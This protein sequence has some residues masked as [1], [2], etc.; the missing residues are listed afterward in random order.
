MDLA[1]S[2]IIPHLLCLFQE[3]I[4]AN[5]Q[6]VSEAY[7]LELKIMNIL[8]LWRNGSDNLISD[9]DDYMKKGLFFSRSNDPLA[10]QARY[11]R[12][13]DDLFKLN[14]YEVPDDVVRRHD[15]KILDIILKESSVPFWYDISD[16]EAHESMLPEFRLQDIHEFRL[17]LKRVRV[18]PDE[19]E[20]IQM[21]ES[22][23]DKRRRK[24]RM[25]KSRPV[26]LSGSESD[27]RIE[28]NDSL[29]PSQKFE[30]KLSSYLL[31]RLMNEMNPHYC[32][33]P[34]PALFVTLIMLK[35]YS[36]K[37]KFFSYGIRYMELV[38]NEIA[39]PDLNTRTFPV[40]FGSDGSFVG[41]RVYSHYP[42][43]L[44]MILND[45][46]Y[47]LTYS[48]LHKFQE[49]ELD[50]ND[51][52]LLHMLRTPNDGR[53]LKKAV[54]RLNHYYGLKFN[55]KTTDCGVVN[56]MD[57]THKHPITK[58]ADF[59]SPVLP[60]TNSFNKAEIC[61][62]H[63]S[64]IL[65]RAVFTDT[66]R[67][68]IRED[69]K[70]VA[71]L[72][73]PKLYEHVSKLVDMRVNYTI[74]YDLM[75]LRV[76]LNLGGYSRSN[77]ITDFRKTIDEIT[78]MNEGFLSGADPE[79]NIDTLN[80]WMAP[81]MED[82]GYR[83]TKSI[84]FGKFR[85]AKY[86][87]DLEAKS[88]ID[89]YVTAR[90]AGIGNLRISIETDKRKYKVRT[91]S[92]SAFV[93][94]MGSGI[95][96]VNPV[97]NEPMMLTDYLLTQ[98][99]ETRANLEA[100]IDSGSKSDSEL[101]RILG[102]N[103]IGS[104]S[105][106]AWRP[107]RPIYINVLQ[108][109]LAQAFIIGPHI[110]ATVNQHEYQP[111]SLWFTGDD[112]GVGFATL[113]QS[114]TADII[115][116]AIEASS[117]GKALSV[118]ADCSSWDQTYL[119][120][121]MIPYYNGIKRALLE[122]QQADMRNFYMIDSGR[123]GVPGMKLSEIVDWF[124]SFQTKRI[125]NASYLKERHSFVVKYMWSGRLDTFFMNSVQNALITRR[126]AEEVSLRV[127]NTGLS[128]FQVAGDD[129]IM[130][131][132]G[133]SISTTEQVTRINEITVRNYEESNHIINPQK[134]V[135]SHISGEYAKIY[136]YAGMH[137]RDPSIQL[138]ES[139]KDS[140]AS[141]VTESLREF[142]Q[143]IYEYNKRAIGTLRVNAL[144]GRLIAGLAYS[145]NCPQYDASKR[146]YANMKYYP[147]P[148]SVIAPAAFKGGLGLSFTGLSLNE[149]LF[150]KL[151]L[152]E[153]VS[154]G[155]H[156]I[157]MISFEA[158][159][160]VSNSLSAYYLK[161]QKDLLRDMKLGKHL[162]KVKGISFKSSDLA[163]SGSD[164]SQGL[165]LKRESIDKVKLEVSRKSIRDLRSSG[166]SVPSTH[167]Y[168]NLPYASLHQSFKSLKVDRDTSKFTNERLLVS[169]LE[170]KSDIPRVSVTSQYPVYDLINISKVDELNVRSGGPVRFI[171]APIEGK[172]LEE[173]IGTRQ[174]VQFKNRG[175]G[176][177]QEVLHFIRS[178]GL[179]IT[180]QALIDLIIKSGVLLMINPQ[181]GLIDLFQSLSGDTASS[182][183]LANF[184]MA[185]KPH[186]EDNAIS[187]TIAGSL[188]ENCDSR[189]ENVKN[190]VSVL[191]TGMQKDL[192][193]MFYYVG[194]V[195]YAQRL[196]WSGGHSSKI[197]VSIDEDKLADF[198]RGS[199]PIT[200]RRKAMAGTKREPINLS[201]NFSY[202]I[203]EPD[204]EISEYDPLILCHP[205]SMP[206]FGNWQEKYSV[207]Q[208]DEQM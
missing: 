118:L 77:Q 121:T 87:S 131:Y 1:R 163:F 32:G 197:F 154:Q 10:L 172:L 98:T 68:H 151:H 150:I 13:Y 196:I 128:W 73:L 15:N 83:L 175:Y 177:S 140:G 190:F 200:R 49:F 113:Y 92:K 184:F 44:R 202:E 173:N 136:Y 107:V 86:P 26:W 114:G 30:T 185:E 3:I 187:L 22:Q 35:A 31:N 153:A 78:K 171:S 74:I 115:V 146:T 54:T 90:S 9:N 95:L 168:E 147:P 143:V 82:C 133:S 148:T 41:T 59:T 179:V 61:Y 66:V 161:D 157:S 16:D 108:A 124:N 186:W 117:T 53:Q 93:N 8:T 149:V 180:E 166:I 6:K 84:L 130:V 165:N 183:H 159:E 4:Q 36:I 192:Q 69:L 170:Y 2:D 204:R 208:S 91:T 105:T 60:M 182:M 47:L 116:P 56:G 46:T 129:A 191:A 178:N 29:K 27:R 48:D 181:R 71:D 139:E 25:E 81:T 127:S 20:E 160:V 194:F 134:T 162:E 155:L 174:G 203:S 7:D 119:T 72:D 123:T 38:C 62:G 33:H 156:V 193:R 88:N 101:M 55:P 23:S 19:S 102:Q 103:S 43:K 141:D 164:F 152:H 14:N 122:Y 206:F 195:Y 94:A 189:I 111:T 80:A 104:R 110:N 39:G 158:N 79:K 65:N 201:A 40:L 57:F 5:I 126:I 37:N 169:L 70:N 75:F 21:D 99:P 76:M 132:D 63:N 120:A 167:A 64:K 52:V 18:V 45:L 144:Y 142:G 89:Y 85:K 112:L 58:T 198:L 28:L 145:V 24:K 205:L 138:H 51:E 67:G 137:F 11:A 125:F 97:S 207:M 17:N 176:G 96:D 109:H 34:L 50:V 100:A 188:L 199:K 135:I 106:T 12:M 42:I